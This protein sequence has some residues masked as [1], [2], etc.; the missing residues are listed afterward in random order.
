MQSYLAID[1]PIKTNAKWYQS[2]VSALSGY[3]ITWQGGFHITVAFI[4][5]ELSEEAIQNVER[6]LHPILSKTAVQTICLNKLDAFTTLKGDQHI[7]CITSVEPSRQFLKLVDDI[8]GQLA[9]FNV[10]PFR[11]HI[12]LGR[13]DASN[14]NLAELKS[15]IES[16]QQP[17]FNIN[18]TKVKYR[19]YQGKGDVRSW[20]FH[21]RQ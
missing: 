15:K 1:V 20:N 8:K 11:M 10:T 13:V 7:I 3:A 6:T 17:N 12:T 16:L 19:M 2:L 18:L 4:N 21:N 5:D 9:E 14:V